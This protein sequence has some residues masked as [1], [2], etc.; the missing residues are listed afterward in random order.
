MKVI[1]VLMS[2]IAFGQSSH[3]IC[4]KTDGQ[5]ECQID[6]QMDSQTDGQMDSQTDG[7]MDIQTDTT[8]ISSSINKLVCDSSES[9]KNNFYPKLST[10]EAAKCD[11]VLCY[12]SVNVI[13]EL[14]LSKSDFYIFTVN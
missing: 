5:M 6:G 9:N 12:H 14:K 2:V 4:E 3:S 7:Q 1:L 11:Y 10:V 8:S 13:K